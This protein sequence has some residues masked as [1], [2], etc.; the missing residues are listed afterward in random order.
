MR[1]SGALPPICLYASSDRRHV[2]LT[3][4]KP[5]ASPWVWTGRS[6]TLRQATETV[7]LWTGSAVCGKPATG[8]GPRLYCPQHKRERNRL[9]QK[10]FRRDND[11]AAEFYAHYPARAERRAITLA[12]LAVELAFHDTETSTSIQAHALHTRFKYRILAGLQARQIAFGKLPDGRYCAIALESSPKDLD[13]SRKGSRDYFML[14]HLVRAALLMGDADD[15]EAYYDVNRALR[16]QGEPYIIIGRIDITSKPIFSEDVQVIFDC[17]AAEMRK[18][19]NMSPF[20]FSKLPDDSVL[21]IIGYCVK[22]CEE[23]FFKAWA[24]ARNEEWE[25]AEQLT[26]YP[27]PPEHLLVWRRDGNG[28][29][30]FV[31]V[32]S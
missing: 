31:L 24:E 25:P 9:K 18:S 14:E 28:E 2:R 21:G 30:K 29:E 17:Y 7:E 13:L 23:G 5:H 16:Q 1:P 11:V 6:V 4:S 3:P 26:F 8:R 19:L 10:R 22:K 12:K 20:V 32:Y 27:L 15:T